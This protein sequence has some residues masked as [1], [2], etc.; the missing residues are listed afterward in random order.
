MANCYKN[1]DTNT[2]VYPGQVV[3]G[4]RTYPG[5]S[6]EAWAKMGFYPHVKEEPVVVE[7]PTPTVVLYS[8]LKILR[9]LKDMGLVQIFLDWLDSDRLIKA[10]WDASQNL[11][12]DDQTFMDALNL[13]AT[14]NGLVKEQVDGLLLECIL[15]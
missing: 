8:K 2:V 9:K 15:T 14:A 6:D 5:A 1:P 12:S 10:E 7:D 11:A 3:N 13:F 4:V